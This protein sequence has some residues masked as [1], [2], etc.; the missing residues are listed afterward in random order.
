MNLP[1]DDSH[2]AD[3]DD[4]EELREREDDYRADRDEADAYDDRGWDGE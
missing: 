1:D 4:A 3:Q 2:L